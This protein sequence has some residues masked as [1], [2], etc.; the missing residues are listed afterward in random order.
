MLRCLRMLK[1]I[2][3][4]GTGKEAARHLVR[5]VQSAGLALPPG[6]L[7][8]RAL[9]GPLARP[10]RPAT[11]APLPAITRLPCCRSQGQALT[12]AGWSPLSTLTASPFQQIGQAAF[13]SLTLP[14]RVFDLNSVAN[15]PCS[16][17]G[18]AN[19]LNMPSTVKLEA[20]ENCGVQS[21]SAMQ[22]NLQTF[23]LAEMYCE[24]Q[25]YGPFMPIKVHVR[26]F[27]PVAPGG[28]Q[29]L[30]PESSFSLTFQPI[31]CICKWLNPASRSART[32]V[33]QDASARAGSAVLQR[34][35]AYLHHQQTGAGCAQGLL[36]QMGTGCAQVVS[37]NRLQ[38]TS[39]CHAKPPCCTCVFL[40]A[41]AIS[42]WARCD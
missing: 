28:E 19:S 6:T 20:Q 41:L 22:I 26:G 16:L 33:W 9:R 17:E 7:S 29:Q 24:R 5:P 12:G 31:C 4:A 36:N 34:R 42:S 2:C 40:P 11:Q 15:V 14:F 35:P 27:N 13:T 39:L 23:S 21:S 1:C 3:C 25:S 30:W 18:H 37:R 10:C 32:D 8:A 38:V